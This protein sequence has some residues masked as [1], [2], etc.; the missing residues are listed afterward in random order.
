ML[1]VEAN[2]KVRYLVAK[3]V[4][5]GCVR[6]KGCGLS[7]EFVHNHRVQSNERHHNSNIIAKLLSMFSALN[8]LRLDTCAI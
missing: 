8:S 3:S 5:F 7:V 1:I 6:A 2:G 4:C